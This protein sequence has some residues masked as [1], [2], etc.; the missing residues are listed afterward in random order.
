M[1]G[2]Q[3]KFEAILKITK[4]SAKQKIEKNPLMIS[5]TFKARS[6][7]MNDVHNDSPNIIEYVST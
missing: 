3:L 4:K 5:Q 7:V 6:E 1:P 2:C